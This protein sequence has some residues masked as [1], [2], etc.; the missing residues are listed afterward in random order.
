[1]TFTAGL[2]VTVTLRSPIVTG[3]DSCN[4][5]T[6]TGGMVM[7]GERCLGLVVMTHLRNKMCAVQQHI[8][9]EQEK[10]QEHRTDISFMV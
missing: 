6:G 10:E 1:M 3:T 7:S 2:I 5:G 8:A 9:G 4:Q